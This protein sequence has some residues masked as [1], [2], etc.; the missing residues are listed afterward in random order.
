MF[1]LILKRANY[2]FYNYSI[3]HITFMRP[4][5]IVVRELPSKS[6]YFIWADRKRLY[7]KYILPLFIS[8]E[9]KEFFLFRM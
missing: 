4:P 9:S 6:H 8:K 1:Y 5:N 3:I 2:E 7:C